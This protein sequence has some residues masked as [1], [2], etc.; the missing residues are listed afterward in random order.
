MA[1]P[2]PVMSAFL[3]STLKSCAV[4][5]SRFIKIKTLP[6]RTAALFGVMPHSEIR[7]KMA[8]S[9]MPLTIT[10]TA[11]SRKRTQI[12]AGLLVD[13]DVSATEKKMIAITPINNALKITKNSRSL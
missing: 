12:S 7:N 4:T 5:N 8:D 3:E 6:P 13:L 2:T 11:D 9:A 10:V 1:F